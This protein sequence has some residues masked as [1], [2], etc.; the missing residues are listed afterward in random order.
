MPLSSIGFTHLSR[1]TGLYQWPWGICSGEDLQMR[2]WHW[3]LATHCSQEIQYSPKEIPIMCNAVAALEKCGHIHQIHNGRWLFKAILAPKPHQEHVKY[4]ED[5]VWMFCIN[6][7]PLD[8]VTWIIHYLNPC[9]NS[10]VIEEF[11][12]RLW[13]WLYDA[14]SGYHQLA[15][16]HTS[17]E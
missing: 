2:Y 10:A 9:C 16:T 13:M 12:T 4:I 15:V 6:Y 11:G 8:S 5:Y 3:Q 14:P 17:Q 1:N 7:F